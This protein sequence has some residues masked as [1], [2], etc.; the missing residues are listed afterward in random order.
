MA[1]AE[2]LPP[3]DEVKQKS[4]Q[5][6]VQAQ[7]ITVTDPESHGV[8]SRMLIAVARMR[9]QVAATFKPIKQAQDEAKRVTLQ[10]ERVADTPLA[11]A[12]QWLKRGIA[13]YCAEQERLRR[14]EED[15]V[16]AAAQREADEYARH[17][18]EELALEDA[19][20][21]EAAGDAAGAEAILANPVPITPLYVPPVVLPSRVEKQEGVSLRRAWKFRIDNESRIPNRFRS[22]DEAKIRA[23]VNAFKQDAVIDGV[24]IYS[25]NTVVGRTV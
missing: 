17:Q 10:Q 12:E 6:S 13:D 20:A 4:T 18:A 8:A 9:K 15:R 7:A 5:L 14:A 1:I 3:Q 24:T 25:E 2:V 22:V 23:Y 11:E 19:V 16:R 21:A